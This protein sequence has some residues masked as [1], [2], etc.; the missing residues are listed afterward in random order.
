MLEALFE[1]SSME[2]R[3]TEEYARVFILLLGCPKLK[4]KSNIAN[5][6]SRVR[7]HVHIYAG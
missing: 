7:G 2:S 3:D 1:P 4:W 5:Q 6:L